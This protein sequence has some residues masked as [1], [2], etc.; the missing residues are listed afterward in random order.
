M[1]IPRKNPTSEIA[2]TT[3]GDNGGSNPYSA[4]VGRISRRTGGIENAPAA[5]MMNPPMI[6]VRM[7]PSNMNTVDSP[8]RMRIIPPAHPMYGDTCRSESLSIR[9]PL[10]PLYDCDPD[11]VL[12]PDVNPGN[13]AVG[14]PQCGQ[15]GACFL[16][17]TPQARQNASSDAFVRA[18]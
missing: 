17:A 9:S 16:I 6:D 10:E 3:P 2:A 15:V 12:E 5:M 7:N 18:I 13:D 11:P 8:N 14:D 4:S 1:N